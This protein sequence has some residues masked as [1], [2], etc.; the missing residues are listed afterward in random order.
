[1]AEDYLK[2]KAFMSNWFFAGMRHVA[3]L[4]RGTTIGIAVFTV[5]VAEFTRLLGG[6]KGLFNF[7]A[8]ILQV[9]FSCTR[10]NCDSEIPGA[11]GPSRHG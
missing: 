10:Y 2:I 4:A 11:C 6:G 7:R 3:E 8:L 5:I 1:V 9:I